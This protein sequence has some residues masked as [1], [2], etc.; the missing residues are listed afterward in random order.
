[1][2]VATII[3]TV[4][5]LIEIVGVGAIVI[6]LLLASIRFA[7]DESRG[8]EHAYTRYRTG[9]GRT[10]L[11]G[12]ELLVAADIVSSVAVELRIETIGVLAI[13]VVVRT[14]LAWSLEVEIEGRWPWQQSR[15]AGA[16]RSITGG[17]RV[18]AEGDGGPQSAPG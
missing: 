16:A 3:E 14:F 5:K 1:M 11:L 17:A 10:L 2:Q 8:R 13:L 7:V 12:L 4:A 15:R 18:G 9:M 6:G